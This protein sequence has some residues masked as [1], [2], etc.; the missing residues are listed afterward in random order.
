MIDKSVFLKTLMERAKKLPIGHYLDIRTYKR[1]RSVLLI[2]EGEDSY[3]IV[4][5]GFYQYEFKST[6]KELKR[7]FKKILK[8]EF[9]RSHKIRLYNM[10]EFSE[11]KAHK[12][13]R[14]KI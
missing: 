1:N 5:N 8:R 7:L 12:I 9:P 13:K 2:R 6:Y 10:G 14:K 11:E 4:E 3:R